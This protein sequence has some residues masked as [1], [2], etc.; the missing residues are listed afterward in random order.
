MKEEVDEFEAESWKGGWAGRAGRSMCQITR[1]QCYLARALV[2]WQTVSFS[3]SSL[4]F[5]FNVHKVGVQKSSH[6]FVSTE[7]FW[8][9]TRKF[10]CTEERSV[11][12]GLLSGMPDNSRGNPAPQSNNLSFGSF[13]APVETW[14]PIWTQVLHSHLPKSFSYTFSLVARAHRLQYLIAA[15]ESI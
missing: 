14:V 4:Q 1:A 12:A 15:V 10:S 6:M 11:T 3:F 8:W 9:I 13:R 2:I 5:C 7:L